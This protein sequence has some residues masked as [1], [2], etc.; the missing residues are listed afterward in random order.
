[1]ILKSLKTA[2]VSDPQSARSFEKVKE[3]TDQI[4]KTEFLV[5]TSI[6]KTIGTSNTEI[7]H[8]LDAVP[9]GFLIVDQTANANVWRISWNNKT[10]TLKA[11]SSVD[12]KLWI[13]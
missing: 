4:M 8:G 1:M 7:P 2:E 3:F 6:S 10:I 12:V 13:F 5:G 9:N 11:S